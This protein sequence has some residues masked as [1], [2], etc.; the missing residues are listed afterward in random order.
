MSGK[1]VE[2]IAILG[3][4]EWG[5]WR[6]VVS[7]K[8]LER[9]EELDRRMVRPDVGEIVL[10]VVNELSGSVVGAVIPDAEYCGIHSVRVG[11]NEGVGCKEPIG[12]IDHEV[13]CKNDLFSVG[14]LPLKV[15]F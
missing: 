6:K 7:Y 10:E 11:L 3:W 2:G 1:G 14:G 9:F 13:E 12:R 8:D 15:M 5:D 4:R